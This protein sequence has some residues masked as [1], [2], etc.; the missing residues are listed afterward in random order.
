[1][2]LGAVSLLKQ[3][4]VD[5]LGGMAAS[6]QTSGVPQG[7]GNEKASKTGRHSKCY[8]DVSNYIKNVL[9]MSI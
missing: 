9:E 4:S 2:S 5:P 8:I 7:R 6:H 1:M 3:P